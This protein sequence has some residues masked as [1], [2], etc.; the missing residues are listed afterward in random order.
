MAFFHAHKKLLLCF[1]VLYVLA[2]IISHATLPAVHVWVIA[3]VFSVLMNLVYITQAVSLRDHMF[4]EAA[5]AD[6]LI[7][8]SILGVL[9]HPLFVIAAIFGHGLWDMSKHWGFGV[10]FFSWYVWGCAIVDVTYGST[11]L[12]YYL[13]HP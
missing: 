4:T 3:A 2:L 8:L 12:A 5:V 6:I 7:L 9:I 10:P 11:L 13:I 1:A